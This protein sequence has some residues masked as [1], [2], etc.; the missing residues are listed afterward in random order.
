MDVASD[1]LAN[2]PRTWRCY[3][4]EEELRHGR[5]MK[6]KGIIGI[7]VFVAW[8]F[9]LCYIM[10]GLTSVAG[11]GDTQY[12]T[13]PT[14]AQVVQGVCAVVAI[15][16]FALQSSMLPPN[17][18]DDI[19]Y[20]QKYLGGWVFLTRH[21]LMLQ[22]VHLTVSLLASILQSASLG[23]LTSC[24]SMWIGS[25]GCFVTVQYFSLVHFNPEFVSTC[26]ERRCR[27]PPDNLRGKCFWI[28][29]FALP[30]AVLDIV[31]ARSHAELHAHSSLIAGL[32]LVFLYVVFYLCLIVA[33][34]YASGHWPYAVLK[35]FKT[36][37]QWAVF[38][39]AQFFIICVFFLILCGLSYLP[40]TW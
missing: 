23:G 26:Q 19:Y 30:L 18:S 20:A 35:Q 5:Y 2:G 22:A 4:S 10:V 27:D 9:A 24:I 1:L 34:F 25:L 3:Y 11:H 36:C 33:N 38:L 6:L 40:S 12:T 29:I 28:H 13:A 21:C 14:W 31:L 16:A 32:L 17:K 39:V 15:G 37:R 8:Y 7:P